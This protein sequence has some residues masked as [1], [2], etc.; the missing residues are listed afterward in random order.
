MFEAF[1]ATTSTEGLQPLGAASQ[2]SFELV[3]GTVRNQL[4]DAHADL[5][6]EPVATQHGDAV[7]WYAAHRGQ[8]VAMP[9]LPEQDQAALRQRLGQLIGDIRAEAETLGQSED[10]DDQRLAEALRNALEIPDETMIH[11]VRDADGTLHPVLVHWSWIR[12]EQRAVRGILT[13]MVPRAVP[14]SGHGATS[15]AG[16]APVAPGGHGALPWFLIWLGWLL[17]AILFAIILYLLIA[18][19]GVDRRGLIFCP[20]D[21]PTMITGPEERQV[22]ED[23]IAQ[24]E[25]EIALADRACKPTVP[26]VPTTAP[27]QAP[28]D[29]ERRMTVRGAERGALNFALE[30][31]STDDLDLHVTCPSGETINFISRSGCGGRLDLDANNARS[32][33]ITDPVENVVFEQARTGIYKVRIHLPVSRTDTSQNF[34]LHVLRRD[35]QPQVYEGTVGPEQR[36]WT[37]NISISG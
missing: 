4:G 25:R 24:L 22:I 28:S 36:N 10:A 6:A 3:T 12:D 26:L 32:E 33:K 9:D 34:R 5:F 31:A 23:E 18:P 37:V 8:A 19:C 29:V 2:R 11:G 1:L 15:L 21:P 13:G 17:L 30:W 27:A 7:D 20:T 14:L 35:G 16:A